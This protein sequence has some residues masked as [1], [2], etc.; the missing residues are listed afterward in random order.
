WF[1]SRAA[2]ERGVAAMQSAFAQASLQSDA[3]VSPVA[4]P[5]AEIVS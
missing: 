3:F 2:A 4:G 5:K 1:A